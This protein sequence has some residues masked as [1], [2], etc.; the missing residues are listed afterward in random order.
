MLPEG[1]WWGGG[2]GIGVM[3]G[4]QEGKQP[5]GGSVSPAGQEAGELG[6][7]GRFL[8]LH[9]WHWGWIMW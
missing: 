3:C 4:L 7:W 5:G 9:S 6:N 8:S 2:R 1:G